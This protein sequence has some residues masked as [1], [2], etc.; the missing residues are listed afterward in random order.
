MLLY[1][2]YKDFIK[3]NFNIK[4]F[5]KIKM[6]NN[7]D[8][9]KSIKII[10]LGDSGVGKSSIIQR[11][12]EDKFDENITATFGSNFL[13]KYVNL[14]GKQYKLEIWDTAGQEEFRSITGIFIKNSKIIILV[15]NVTYKKSFESLEYWY[16]F[17]I[18]ELGPNIIIGLAGNKTD[19]ILEDGYKEEVTQE[20]GQEYAKKINASF[21][22][23][24]AKESSQEIILLFEELVS[25]YIEI[26]NLDEEMNSTVKLNNVS[27]TSTNSL[28]KGNC[29]I[30]SNKKAIKIK[31][32][33]LGSNGV[34]KTS[35]IKAIKGHKDILNFE[36][37][38]K[39][40]KENL[41]Y[42]KK[43]QKI[44][45]ELRDTSGDDCKN[46]ILEQAIKGSKVIF[47]VFDLHKK[48]TL[49]KLEDWITNVNKNEN[50]LYLLGYN[51]EAFENKINECNFNN[52]IEQFC[53]KYNIEY[54]AI[55]F[56]DIF[57]VKAIIL[58]NISKYLDCL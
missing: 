57:K 21:A 35:I 43:D 8:E 44:N 58:D 55:S 25:R 30:S 53:S 42:T 36:H 15:Y 20:Q 54:E 45:V 9:E 24:S 23:I 33:F 48:D 50:K 2:Y 39:T 56:E 14:K 26:K 28:D 19:L 37:T 22:L 16:D 13:E 10:L 18:K 31:M 46:E 12:Y 1:L 27:L 52:E 34:G 32:S 6:I 29:C 4:K 17:I 5:I 3:I 38:K 41:F 11:Y 51:N 47:L 7:N 49:Y 40:S